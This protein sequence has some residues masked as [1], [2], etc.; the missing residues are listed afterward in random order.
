ME[1]IFF[2]NI[3][4]GW[5]ADVRFD[6][7]AFN[8]K[9]EKNK[10]LNQIVKI[11]IWFLLTAAVPNICHV[12]IIYGNLWYLNI[13]NNTLQCSPNSGLPSNISTMVL[14]I[15]ISLPVLNMLGIRYS[16]PIQIKALFKTRR[17]QIRNSD[18]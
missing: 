2:V 18:N 6:T 13:S 1:F 4:I 12:C 11:L 14:L 10:L 9:R 15:I 3:L 5:V 17:V 8:R 7:D 16:N